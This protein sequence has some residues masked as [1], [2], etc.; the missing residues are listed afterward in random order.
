MTK[1]YR[2]KDILDV[3]TRVSLYQTCINNASGKTTRKL[4]DNAKEMCLIALDDLREFG[5]IEIGKL[6]ELVSKQLP[7]RR[8]PKRKA[9]KLLK[10]VYKK[11]NG[12]KGAK[13]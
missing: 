4:M 10:A 11:Q 2:I 8:T 9:E 7:S 5:G 12:K 6:Q 3:Q 13:K 1:K